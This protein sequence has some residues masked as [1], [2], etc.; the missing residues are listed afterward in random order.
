MNRKLLN[1]LSGE[2]KIKVIAIEEAK[3]LTTTPLDKIV[4]S[5]LT[6]EMNEARRNEG[7]INKDKSIAL[8]AQESSSDDNEDVALLSRKI[9]QMLRSP[10]NF[11]STSK[12]C[13]ECRKRGHFK[14]E[15]LTSRD[16]EVVDFTRSRVKKKSKLTNLMKISRIEGSNSKQGSNPQGNREIYD[17][18]FKF[19]QIG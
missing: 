13:Y 1:A 10:R 8:Q 14:D 12:V 6:H 4:G 9:A 15:C 2:W 11:G 19:D 16:R 18:L 17:D 7:T 5:L 3:N